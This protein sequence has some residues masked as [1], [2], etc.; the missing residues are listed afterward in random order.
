MLICWCFANEYHSLQ[1]K[2]V[3]TVA[4]KKPNKSDYI[5][6]RVYCLIIL[7]ECIGKLLKKVVVY[8]LTYLTGQYNLIL[9]PQF[10]G[11]ANFST[12]DTILTF[13]HDVYNSQNYS[14]AI[15]TLTFDIKYYFDFVNHKHLLSKMKKYCISLELVKQIA[16]FLFDKDSNMP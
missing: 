11:R 10:G 9:D 16:N 13:V 14:L 6:P 5:Q 8:R 4:F 2:E 12:I 3:I 7:L 1:Q 15:S